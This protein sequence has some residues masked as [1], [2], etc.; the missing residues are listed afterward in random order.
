MASTN[1]ASRFF[2]R[3][4][5]RE[6]AFCQALNRAVRFRP[7]LGYFR[8]VSRLGDGWFWYGLILLLPI[9]AP[10]VGYALALL[11]TFTGLT[12]TLTYKTLKRW[13][14]R[15]RPFISFPAI[16]CATPPLDRY[17]F[18]SGHTL[19]AS[20]F[21]TM[22][23]IG[24]PAMAWAVLPFTLSVVASR[25]VLGLHYPSDVAAGAIIGST[26]GWLSM[27]LLSSGLA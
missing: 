4:D 22:L 26:M 3:A 25:V 10:A 21:Q 24:L 11:M 5:Q 15:E 2:E 1:R 9:L 8:V 23:F 6:L 14:I 16:D 19:H 17:S 27:S 7:V 13:L 20:C 18:P 12:C